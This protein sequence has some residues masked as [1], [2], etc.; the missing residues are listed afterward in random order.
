[1][2]STNLIIYSN[3][4]ALTW[5]L[6]IGFAVILYVILDGFGLGIGIISPLFKDKHEKSIIISTILPVW[7]GNETWLVFVGATLY[8]AFPQAFSTILPALYIPILIMIIALLFRGAS[9]EFRLK[10]NR[11]QVIWNVCFFVGSVLATIAQGIILASLLTGFNVSNEYISFTFYQWFNPFSMLCAFALVVGYALLGSNRLII[12]TSGLIQ[13]KCY[14]ISSKLQYILLIALSIV[15]FW[16]QFNDNTIR[17]LWFNSN[18]SVIF[19]LLFIITVTSFIIHVVSLKKRKE[20]LPYWSLITLFIASYVGLLSSIYPYI[21]PHKLTYLEAS[22]TASCLL[23][24]LIGALIMLP[25]LLFYTY[26]AYRIFRG[27]VSEKIEY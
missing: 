20:R 18:R 6:I 3:P 2:T 12:K 26:Y 16:T 21:I 11:S 15:I 1:M 23:F 24:M 19:W 8:G 7:D 14:S 10:A 17:E 27:K 4:L 25:L 22:S 9:F 13:E 5:L